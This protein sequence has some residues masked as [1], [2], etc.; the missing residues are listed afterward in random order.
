MGKFK[1]WWFSFI[2]TLFFK[3]LPFFNRPIGIIT[4]NQL[5]VRLISNMFF[6]ILEEMTLQAI[7]R[8]TLMVM[9]IWGKWWEYAAP[10]NNL[11][12]YALRLWAMNEFPSTEQPY[13]AVDGLEQRNLMSSLKTFD[14]VILATLIIL[15]LI[16]VA[17]Q[18]AANSDI[19]QI[20]LPFAQLTS[21]ST[22]VSNS[23][24]MWFLETYWKDRIDIYLFFRFSLPNP[25]KWRL[26]W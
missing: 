4:W 18:L 23:K 10:Y 24:S 2:G 13:G 1:K 5:P 14:G 7:T 6:G 20:N 17:R 22:L 8:D 25:P 21:V 16:P 9:K 15:L 19:H 11:P 26:L 12:Y 3:W